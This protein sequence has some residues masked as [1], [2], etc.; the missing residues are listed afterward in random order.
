LARAAHH[1]HAFLESLDSAAA[2]KLEAAL[3][4]RTGPTIVALNAGD[5]NL[6][7]FDPYRTLIPLAHPSQGLGALVGASITM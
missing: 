5:F 7:V 1:A 3:S 6:G 4:G 2:A